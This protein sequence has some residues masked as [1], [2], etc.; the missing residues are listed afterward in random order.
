MRINWLGGQRRK[1][2]WQAK[3][4]A[5]ALRWNETVAGRFRGRCW[6]AMFGWLPTL[7]LSSAG[8]FATGA[9]VDYSRDV[10]PL[11]A[12]KCFACH[13]PETQEGGL[14]LHERDAAL[15]PLDSGEIAI[16][17]ENPA[18]SE[19]L[20]RVRSSDDDLRMPPA[21]HDP[22]T[23]REIELLQKWIEQGADFAAH[24]AFQPLQ[25]IAVPEATS[26]QASAHPV[27]RFVDAVLHARQ[28]Q[29]APQ[30][31]R[32]TLI[33]RVTFDLTGLPPT[34]E[35]IAAFVN[36]PDPQAYERLV[37]ELLASPQ[38][39]EKWARHWLDLVRYA[40]TNSFERDGPK[41]NAWKYRDYV[42]NA[43]NADKPYDQ[44]LREQLAG[45]E[46]PERSIETITATGFY[47]LGIW[48]DE[49][50]DPLQAR[51]DEFDDLVTTISQ[52]LLGLTLNCSRCH[53]HKID[54]LPQ[55]DY[56]Q[57]VAF[58]SEL[59]HFGHQPGTQTDVSEPALIAHYARLDRELKALR[60]RI[61]EHEQLGIVKMPAEDQRATE[62]RERR[63]VLERKLRQ[64]LD[65]EQWSH[66]ETL[67]A[68]EQRLEQEQKSLP[69]RVLVMSVNEV[70]ARPADTHILFRGNPHVPGEKVVPAF[71]RLYG[72]PVPEIPPVQ[73]GQR[74]SG[75]RSVLAQWITSPEN[76][77][78]ARVMVNRLW[79]HHFG[80]GI[81]RSSNNFGLLGTP[82]THPELL[83][84]LAQQFVAEGWR[85]KPMHRLLVLSE[86]YQRSSQAVP[87]SLA[88][89]P[90]ND[91]F[92]RFDL[93]RLSAEEIRDAVLA[94]SGTLN[95]KMHGPSIY[96]QLSRET[97]STQSR[98]GEGWG[99]SSPEEQNRRSVYIY[100]KRSLI[101]PELASFDFP[102][103][104]V[105][106]EARFVT[107]QPAQ[108]LNLLNGEFLNRQ[109]GL[110]AA[111]VEREAET[112][113]DRINRAWQL[114]LGRQP[115]PDEAR[116]S[117]EL[118]T[119]LQQQH[120]LTSAASWKY[121]CLYLLNL[122]EF[123]F[124]D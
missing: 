68:D 19:L 83:D 120:Q 10:R 86:A 13:G 87:E 62:T 41:A 21:G 27:D 51:A 85:M 42:I 52:G 50:A 91:T 80:R 118:L 49:P 58:L 9:E 122:N 47:R 67:K 29:P 14:G 56:Y 98:P 64:Y 112:E 45:D 71:P 88:A 77:L 95:L 123:V 66:Y 60:E 37:D 116:D 73:P 5:V 26:P 84:W 22:L 18:E 72:D 89:D 102:E 44:F 63:R 61:R 119:K 6:F 109:A 82:P 35:Q 105:T 48:D 1:R 114:A 38:Y 76:R 54:P 108:S 59:K 3:E 34:P 20:Q 31:D 101:P 25:P 94:T 32:R 124:L 100:V 96:P 40:E 57:M 39:G 75:R 46:L 53:D 12:R 121:F 97:L 8:N 33:R 117:Q 4:T 78:T 104:D 65:D 15:Q 110:F 113:S 115:S 28:I 70:N 36:N 90:E 2:T 7:L 11:L 74:T 92:W 99:R 107:I 55:A 106:C 24:W 111:R 16:R 30:A 17:P 81:V 103:T 69:P 93:R 23:P 79:Q 43:F